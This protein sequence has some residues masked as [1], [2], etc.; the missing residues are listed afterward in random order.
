[1]NHGLPGASTLPLGK[2]GEDMVVAYLLQEGF[3]ILE[4]N[5]RKQYGEID[6]IACN[7]EYLVF[8]EVKMRRS[9]RFDF[10]CVVT[11][12]KQQKIAF[13]ARHYLARH[14]YAYKVYR[15]DV[16]LVEGIGTAAKIT[17]IPQAF[18]IDTW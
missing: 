16:A 6:I 7:K 2:Q 8:V 14:T 3:T 11:P 18:V 10:S 12:K 17:Y 1:M 4:R 5:Y 15:F 13:V 9:C